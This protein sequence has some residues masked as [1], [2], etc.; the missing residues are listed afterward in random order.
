VTR[1]SI[2]QDLWRIVSQGEHVSR[3]LTDDEEEY[4]QLEHFIDEGKPP[5]PDTP[6]QWNY[7]VASLF[8]YPV[9]SAYFARFRPPFYP[10]NSFYGSLEFTTILWEAVYYFLRERVHLK[11]ASQEVH[12]RL[13]FGIGFHDQ[14]V[15]D[16]RAHPDEPAL[17]SRRDYSASHAF[18]SALSDFDSIV[19]RSCRDPERRSNVVTFD[20]NHLAQ[21]TPNEVAVDFSFQVTQKLARVSSPFTRFQSLEIDWSMVQP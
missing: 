17:T 8:R 11:R 2:Q 18:A 16:A 4:W 20:I 7:L 12:R 19:Y 5:Y 10:R 1:V 13:A 15:V 9:P 6:K 14:Q 3:A 21:D